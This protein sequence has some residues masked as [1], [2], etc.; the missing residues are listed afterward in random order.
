[1]V[2]MGKSAGF[3]SAKMLKD[4]QLVA[5]VSI[6]L[7]R[8]SSVLVTVAATM[9]ARVG[10]ISRQQWPPSTTLCSRVRR[11]VGQTLTFLRPGFCRRRRQKSCRR[12]LWVGRSCGRRWHIS[13]DLN[14]KGIR[15]N[16]LHGAMKLE[17]RTNRITKGVA[18]KQSTLVLCVR[19]FF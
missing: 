10:V 9:S 14:C 13:N 2:Q 8:C 1:M 19:V 11:I 18:R 15:N 4:V 7:P 3:N 5:A 17:L 12:Q 16:P 6:P